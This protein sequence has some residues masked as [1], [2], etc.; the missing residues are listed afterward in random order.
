MPNH[1]NALTFADAS[2]W[3]LPEAQK[4]TWYIELFQPTNYHTAYGKFSHPHSIFAEYP[5]TEG[6][7][8][9]S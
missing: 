1:V 7:K 9:N 8:R 2:I 5:D 3:H 6:I 4:C